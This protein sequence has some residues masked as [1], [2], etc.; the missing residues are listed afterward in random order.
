MPRGKGPARDIP[1]P[2]ERGM[3]VWGDAAASAGSVGDWEVKEGDLAVA[4]LS[5]LA[6]GC[7]IR[8]GVTSDGG[9]V[10]VTIY[11]GNKLPSRKYVAD[12]ISFDDLMAEIVQMAKRL[13]VGKFGTGAYAN[14]SSATSR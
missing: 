4:I 7:A 3:W 1:D 5:V 12:S 14:G 2:E 11:D 13:H 8:F 10:S 6:S 9:A